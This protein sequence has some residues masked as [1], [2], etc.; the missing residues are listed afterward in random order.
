[1]HI[2]MPDTL[3]SKLVLMSGNKGIYRSSKHFHHPS[4]IY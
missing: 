2:D 1:M 3:Q 4:F